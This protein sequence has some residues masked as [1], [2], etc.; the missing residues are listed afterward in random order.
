MSEITQLLYRYS[1]Q[2][3]LV[4]CC[5]LCSSYIIPHLPPVFYLREVLIQFSGNI[6]W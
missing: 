6:Y 3:L 4:Y 2:R 5:F 1:K